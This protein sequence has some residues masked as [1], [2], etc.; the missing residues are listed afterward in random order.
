MKL[1]KART[2]YTM[3]DKKLTDSEI[4]KVLEC[5]VTYEFCTECPLVDNCPSD[6]SLLKSALD[7]IN[8]QKAEIERLNKQLEE[9]KFLESRVNSI[10]NTPKD[11]FSGALISIAEGVARYEAVKEFAERLKEYV[12]SYDVTTGYRVTIVQAVE[13]ETIDNLVKEM[14]GENK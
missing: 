5:C 14:V 7:L 11:T 6:Y 12:E 3:T 1:M 10:K 8:R 13:E 2:H 9:F 4:V